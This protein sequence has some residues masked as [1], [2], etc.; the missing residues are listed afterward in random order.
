MPMNGFVNFRHWMYESQYGDLLD[1]NSDKMNEYTK[2]HI[3]EG[4]NSP[5]LIS[6]DW[7]SNDQLYIRNAA[8]LERYDFLSCP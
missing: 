3:A 4:E 2:W 7:K 6:P 5:V 1:T 8:F